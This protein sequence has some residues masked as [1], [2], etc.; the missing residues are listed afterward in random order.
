[1]THYLI[2]GKFIA[3]VEKRKQPLSAED[4]SDLFHDLDQKGHSPGMRMVTAACTARRM[5]LS[6]ANIQWGLIK[7]FLKILFTYKSQKIQISG[8]LYFYEIQVLTNS[9]LFLL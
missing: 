7:W 6:M 8:P 5:M 4:V 2:A 9:N 3:K 1:M